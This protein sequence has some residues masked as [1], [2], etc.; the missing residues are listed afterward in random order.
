LSDKPK[1]N[2]KIQVDYRIYHELE[3]EA[4]EN[5]KTIKEIAENHIREENNERTRKRGIRK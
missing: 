2:K 1:R 5:D 3:K 4:I